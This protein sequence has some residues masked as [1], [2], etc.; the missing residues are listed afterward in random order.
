MIRFISFLWTA[1]LVFVSGFSVTYA[2]HQKVAEETLLSGTSVGFIDE[3]SLPIL[4]MLFVLM[5]VQTYFMW[6][7]L[8]KIKKRLLRGNK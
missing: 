1:A 6:A 5:S 4:I 3:F 7:H 2:H 8:Y